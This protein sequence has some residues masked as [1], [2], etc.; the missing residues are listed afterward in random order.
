MITTYVL[1]AM[2]RTRQSCAGISLWS[3]GRSLY[4]LQIRCVG[5][6][7]GLVFFPWIKT[8]KNKIK[9]N[10]RQIQSLTAHDLIKKQ[11]KTKQKTRF[12]GEG[13]IGLLRHW[14]PHPHASYVLRVKFSIHSLS[15]LSLQTAYVPYRSWAAEMLM[16]GW[17]WDNELVENQPP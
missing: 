3:W 11:K 4:L 8:W 6:A 5:F 13:L 10:L 14:K 2:I 12:G 17:L 15:S 9:L 7:R 16:D 1:S